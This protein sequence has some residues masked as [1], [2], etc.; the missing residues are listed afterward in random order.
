MSLKAEL[1]TWQ[2]AL[3][4]AQSLPSDSVRAIS[5]F[6]SI[7]GT[8]KIEYNI[9]SLLAGLGRHLEAIARYRRA[10]ELDDWLV[11]GWFMC[12]V[13]RSVSR[14]QLMMADGRL[15]VSMKLL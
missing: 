8:S 14:L 5:L 9:G 13:S 11:V 2:A 12:G 7:G 4:S 3:K 15:L 1:T 10:T 6:D